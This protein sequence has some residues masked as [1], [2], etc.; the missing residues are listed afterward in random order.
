MGGGIRNDLASEGVA[1][2]LLL[3]VAVELSGKVRLA[4][5]ERVGERERVFGAGLFAGDH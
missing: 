3:G 4:E 2:E 5:M 1:S